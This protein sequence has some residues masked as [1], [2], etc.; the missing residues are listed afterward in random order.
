MGTDLFK[1]T[2]VNIALSFWT[3]RNIL[4]KNH[5]SYWKQNKTSRPK[6]MKKTEMTVKKIA[7]FLIGISNLPQ[8]A[9][10]RDKLIF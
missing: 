9:L 4:K 2:L 3:A 5:D 8:N 10:H 1:N 7:T 6:K